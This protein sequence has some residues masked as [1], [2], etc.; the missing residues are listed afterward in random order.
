MSQSLFKSPIFQTKPM[1]FNVLQWAYKNLEEKLNAY[2]K[3][4]V[5]KINIYFQNT[6][7]CDLTVVDKH[8]GWS[9]GHLWLGK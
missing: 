7:K 1:V 5:G 9:N 4:I 8:I 3:H 6:K 2:I